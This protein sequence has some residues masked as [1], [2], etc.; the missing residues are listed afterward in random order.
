MSSS[1]STPDT[2]SATTTDTDKHH[3]HRAMHKE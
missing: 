3:R 1:M 2:A